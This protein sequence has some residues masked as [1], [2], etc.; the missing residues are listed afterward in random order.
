MISLR[1]AAVTPTGV[2][3][4]AIVTVAGD[5]IASVRPATDADAAAGERFAWILPGFVD[6]HNHGGAGGSFPD[7]DL[8]GCRTAARHHRAH[9]TTTLLAS[10]VSAPGAHLV[11]Q[12]AV[13]ADLADEGEIDGVHLEGPFVNKCRCGA[14]DPA[15]I[16]PGDPDLLARVAEAGRGWLRSVTFAPETAHALE[17]VNVCSHYGM[18]A[19]LGHT[20]ADFD[21]TLAVLEHA[22][23]LGVTVTA[24][25]LFNAMPPIHHRAPGAA[26][27]ML[28]AAALGRMVVE[29]VADGVHLHDR[30]VDLVWDTVT[31]TN[32][33]FVTDAMS[34]AGMADGAYE[35]G[36]LH[37]T[38]TGGIARLTTT[39]G[40]QGSIAGGTSR[41]LEQVQRHIRR[42]RDIAQA[43]A[44]A[45]TTGAKVLGLADRGSIVAGNRADLVCLDADLKLAKV[46]WRGAEPPSAQ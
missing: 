15:A 3:P 25:H 45:A 29:L 12:T 10:L 35:L 33:V 36:D 16:I 2:V 34:A 20:D 4:D 18:V 6:I 23:R 9:G 41:L 44:M 21:A 30:T 14:Q 19:S 26:A 32:A 28:D 37:V 24:T 39:D 13:L 40:T 38:V 1:G 31:P 5:R 42:G 8:A 46:L 17:L 43:A 22:E 11:R 7:S 27:A